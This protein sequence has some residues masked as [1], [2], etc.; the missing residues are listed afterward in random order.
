MLKY[1]HNLSM[2]FNIDN[3]LF[4]E[5]IFSKNLYQCEICSTKIQVNLRLA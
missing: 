5:N 1:K 3:K 4:L 2:L